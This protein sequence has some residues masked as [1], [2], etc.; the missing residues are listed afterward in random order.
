MSMLSIIVAI[1]IGAPILF[2]ICVFLALAPFF[3]LGVAGFVASKLSDENNS[4]TSSSSS[5]DGLSD[6]PPGIRFRIRNGAPS[7]G[8]NARAI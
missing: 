3:L 8:R 6:F 4:T 5:R 2:A 1:L 7:Y